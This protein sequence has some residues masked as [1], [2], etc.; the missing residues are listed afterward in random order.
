MSILKKYWP[1]IILALGFYLISVPL[2]LKVDLV[3]IRLW[4]ESRNAVNAIE[5]SESHNWLVR[6]YNGKPETFET[7][8]PLLIWVQVASIKMFG[9]TE[10]AIRLPSVVFS[11]L[12]LVVL[13]VFL[14]KMTGNM[15]A[16]FGG[17][18]ITATSKGFYGEHLGRFG[19]HEALLVL[20]ILFLLLHVYLYSKSQNIRH[21]YYAALA[22]CL[23]VMCKSV[24]I[25]MVLPGV[26][27]YLLYAKKIKVL[28]TTKHFYLALL[29][30]IVPIAAYYI[31]R[32]QDQPGY[33]EAVW[34]GELFP[35]FFNQSKTYTFSEHGFSFYFRQIYTCLFVHWVW[36]LPAV[37]LA[38]LLL[39][40]VPLEWFFWF[41]NGLVFLLII[42]SGTKHEWYIAPA[43][44]M[45]AGAIATSLFLIIGIRPKRLIWL[46][47]PMACLG[48]MSFDKSYNYI[49]HPY[50][51]Y[52]NWETYGVSYFLKDEKNQPYISSNIKIVLD[53]KK[54]YEPYT[55]Y[56][57]KLALELDIHIKRIEYGNIEPLDTLLVP[58]QT[59]FTK[60]K[61]DYTISVIDSTQYGTR[62]LQVTAKEPLV[63][64]DSISDLNSVE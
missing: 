58:H 37:L 25:C 21:V 19:D 30:A 53:S 42:S 16:S 43:I 41:A 56:T 45:L 31:L 57:K 2:W 17:S 40:K 59:V 36:A 20:L 8:P 60:L 12:S 23:G 44:P 54:I 14:F 52:D 11:L 33:L 64:I 10:L 51:L 27:L 15:L 4:D 18:F 55:F 6:T 38:P 26:A 28:L 5:M 32:E 48:K 47:V 34:Q 9:Y 61:E 24:A 62:L 35:R 22:F 13:F 50:E 46:L 63:Q 49:M 39:K 3:P 7:K 29:T 1:Y